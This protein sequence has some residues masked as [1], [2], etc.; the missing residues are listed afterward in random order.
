MRDPHDIGALCALARVHLAQNHLGTATLLA[1]RAHAS[2]AEDAEPLVVQT[3]IARAQGDPAGEIAAA[4]AAV[5]TDD[6]SPI[7]ALVLGRSLFERGLATEA[8]EQ[9]V[10]AV[11]LG[12]EL[13]AI[14]LALGLALAAQGRRAEAEAQLAVAAQ[15]APGWPEI[16]L[17]LARLK[18][19]QGDAKTALAEANLFL[20]L[21]SGAPAGHPVHALVQRCEEALRTKAQASVVQ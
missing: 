11:E 20:R 14:R 2:D 17:E 18:E 16:H 4:R 7:A 10:H 5:A 15:R 3:E 1:A 8:I 9:L 19:A 6:E 12:P 13:P 21:A